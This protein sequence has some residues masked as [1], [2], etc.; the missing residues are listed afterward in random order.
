M[1][2]FDEHQVETGFACES[3]YSFQLHDGVLSPCR[4]T[5]DQENGRHLETPDGKVSYAEDYFLENNFTTERSNEHVDCIIGTRSND[6]FLKLDADMSDILASSGELSVDCFEVSNNVEEISENLKGEKSF[7]QSCSS[8]RDLLSDRA[9]SASD[10][11]FEFQ[12]DRFRNQEKWLGHVDRVDIGEVDDS[13]QIFES[14]QDERASI[15]SSPRLIT[16]HDMCM[17]PDITARDSMQLF[18]IIGECFD[19]DRDLLPDSDDH[20][21]ECGSRHVSFKS[22]WSCLTPNP[23]MKTILREAEHFID[24]DLLE[25]NFKIASYDYSA[26]REDKDCISGYGSMRNNFGWGNCSTSRC[27]ESGLKDYGSSQGD[28]C[29]FQV[30][31]LDYDLFPKCFDEYSDE[32]KWSSL[33]ACGKNRSMTGTEP[34]HHISSTLCVDE[35]KDRRAQISCHEKAYGKRPRRSLSAPP[36]YRGKKK[37]LASNS[38]L[39]MEAGNTQIATTY[40]APTLKGIALV[41]IAFRI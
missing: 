38:G 3:N 12:I 34:S 35:D 41:Q 10:K 11:G 21:R 32:I 4:E 30:D 18:P 37:F 8:R 29:N 19:E 9:F 16:Q 40:D 39:N 13:S 26:D 27:M 1:L 28:I 14:W 33:E 17:G 7:L 23:F 24:E 2:E 20:F 15:W 5:V 25:K 36:L 22:K 31:N 6:V